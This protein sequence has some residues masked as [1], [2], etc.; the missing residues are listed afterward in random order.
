MSVL[1][2]AVVVLFLAW[3]AFAH[4]AA[5]E[6]ISIRPA[7]GGDPSNMRVRVLPNGDLIASSVPVALLL[8]YGPWR[9]L[10]AV[11]C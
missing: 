3:S 1:H 8:R 2:E 7:R 10:E 4:P 5:F 6:V 11:G 9:H